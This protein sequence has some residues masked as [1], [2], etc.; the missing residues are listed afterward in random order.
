M[1]TLDLSSGI[2]CFLFQL[3]QA[4][5]KKSSQGSE[6]GSIASSREAAGR[7]KNHSDEGSEQVELLLIGRG[8]SRSMS[9]NFHAIRIRMLSQWHRK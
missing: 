8:V 3:P 1:L 5:W 9:I 2:V 7:E 4:Y 6:V